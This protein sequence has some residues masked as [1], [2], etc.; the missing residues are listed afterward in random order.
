MSETSDPI[1]HP[2]VQREIDRAVG[3]C[4]RK[5]GRT[6]EAVVV[7]SKRAEK[8]HDRIDEHQLALVELCGRSG[9]N[10]VIGELRRDIDELKASSRAHLRAS[11]IGAT[12]GGG[13]VYGLI[14]LV[15][16]LT[17]G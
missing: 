11:G 2:H 16:I 5:H 3:E 7:V 17:G 13:T 10:G 15:R 4:D 1:I 8:A 6:Q 12:V 9:K 14:E